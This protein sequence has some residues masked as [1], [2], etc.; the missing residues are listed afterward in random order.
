VHGGFVSKHRFIDHTSGK[1]KDVLREMWQVTAFQ[2]GAEPKAAFLFD[3]VSTQECASQEALKL[4]KYHYGGL[5]VRGNA[6]WDPVDKVTMLTSE[7]HDRKAGDS[8]KARWVHLGGAVDGALTGLAVL[9]H[10][11]NFRAPQPLRLNPKNPQLCIAPSQ[12]GDWEIV[13]GKPYVSRHRFVVADG[14][15]DAKELDR[16]WH[17][18]AHP[19]K[20]EVK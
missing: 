6:A 18:Y 20:V 7:G 1:E 2:A 14:A 13:P 8:T 12:E 11:G 16:L 3:L 9:I 15:V 17:D 5:G 19:P 4:P 10:P